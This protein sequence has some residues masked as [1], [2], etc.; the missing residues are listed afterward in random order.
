M[1]NKI[2]G[3]AAI[4][5]LLAVIIGAF[6]A[7]SLKEKLSPEAL[8]SFE[9]GVRYMMYH[10]LALLIIGNSRMITKKSKLL[11]SVFFLVGIIFF[12]GSI[13]AISTNLVQAKQIW[14][15]TP[16]GGVFFVLGWL[17]SALSFFKST[18]DN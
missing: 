17:I 9:T 11:I 3:F 14:L 10:V 7:H 6:G 13:F 16:L 4:L 12:S 2:L 15:I 5:G 8:Q 18:D 1:N